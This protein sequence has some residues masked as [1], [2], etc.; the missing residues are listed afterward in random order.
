MNLI[1]LQP[2]DRCSG[3][4]Y[5]LA[6]D[7]SEHVRE[8]LRAEVGD[9]LSVGLLNGPLGRGIVRSIEG[10]EV[11]LACEFENQVMEQ[12]GGRVDLVCAL[13]RPQTLKKVLHSAAAMGVSNLY[14]IRSN[15]VEK[16]YFHSPM[17]EPENYNR[18]LIEGLSQGKSTLLP[19]VSFHQRF[20][21]FFE[22]YLP[23]VPSIAQCKKILFSTQGE[24]NLLGCG[25]CRADNVLLALG[26]EGGWVEFEEELM[27]ASGFMP[28]TLGPWILRV[29]NALVAAL[30]QLELVRP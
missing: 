15:R 22:D 26:P 5:I 16:S 6:D 11:V 24:N 29:E 27:I 28:V 23:G 17:L 12:A 19:Q 7:R 14:F 30:G 2:T 25:L 1:I 21:E 8:I 10:R 9:V 4:E 18:F 20:R 3:D 13:P